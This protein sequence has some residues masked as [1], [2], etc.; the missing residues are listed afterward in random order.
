[1]VFAYNNAL[2]EQQLNYHL[3]KRLLGNS[4][5][6]PYISINAFFKQKFLSFV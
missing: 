2:H 1:M 4:L 5:V 3:R 6:T